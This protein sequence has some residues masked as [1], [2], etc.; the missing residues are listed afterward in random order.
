MTSTSISSAIAAM[1]RSRYWALPRIA[2]DLLLWI[3]LALSANA[4]HRWWGYAIAALIIGAA[5]MHDLLVQGHEGTHELISHN[6]AVNEL[7]SWLC[8]ALFGMSAIAHK[9]FHADHHRYPHTE[10]DPEYRL[11]D[12]VVRGVPGW[13]YLIIPAAAQL[14][15]NS[16]PFR[17]KDHEGD[18]LRA[19]VELTGSIVLHGLILWVTG[20]RNYL[21]FVAAPM[22]TGLYLVTVAR[23]I[24]EHHHVASGDDWTN[25]RSVVTNPL[26]EFAWSNVNYHLEHH[27][28]PQ[29][30]FHKLPALRRLLAQDFKPHHSVMSKGFL[31]T[32]ASLIQVKQH[33]TAGLTENSV[34]MNTKQE[35][36]M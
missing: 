2:L 17:M 8:F 23:S 10:R 5:S 11:F 21:L 9:D 1:S 32:A 19:T 14:G 7:A 13:A 35:S 31:R 16:Y 36:Q 6:H 34:G 33:F 24:C 29:V 18:R 26:T 15:V 20:P 22:A 27:L 30:P 25:A 3:T 4:L 28:Y 12:R